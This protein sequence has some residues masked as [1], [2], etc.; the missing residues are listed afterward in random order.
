M[1][2]APATETPI[3][4]GS[5]PEAPKVMIIKTL[6]NTLNLNDDSMNHSISIINEN[7]F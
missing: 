3:T 7:I 4:N 1:C 6:I 5:G 2:A